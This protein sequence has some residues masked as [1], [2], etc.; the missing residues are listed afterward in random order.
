[1]STRAEAPPSL[2][3]MGLLFAG[4]VCLFFLIL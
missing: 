1:M 2:K 3:Q 4:S